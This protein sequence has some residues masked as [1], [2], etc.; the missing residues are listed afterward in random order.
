MVAQSKALISEEEYLARERAAETKSEYR[1]GE[2][3]AMVG[4][5]REH[6]LIVTDTLFALYLQL[7]DRPCEVYPLVMRVRIPE[8]RRYFYPD[9][10]VVCDEP[11]FGDD[12][13]DNL[14]NPTVIIEVL[15]PSTAGYDRGEKFQHYRTIPSLREYLLIAQDAYR[16]EHFARQGE[17]HRLLGVAEG[18]E[19][20]VYL[21]S[22]DCTLRL[23]DVYKKVAELHARR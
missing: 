8:T 14:L 10:I 15:S 21:A 18:L 4:A 11:R 17:Q 5:S 20:S 23:A 13:V 19:A 12:Y 2:V 9:L 1:E 3:V 6:T 16:I 22:I 7:R